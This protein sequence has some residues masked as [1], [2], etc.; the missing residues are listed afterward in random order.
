[1]S[2]PFPGRIIA[3]VLAG[4]FTTAAVSAAEIITEE[5]FI[6]KTIVKEQL[7]KVADNAIF[8][9]D[10]SPSM[11]MN[12]G[13]TDMSAYEVV[14]QEFK[15]R[16][17][18]IPNLGYNFGIYLYT[19]WTPVYP[20]QPYDREKVAEA[21]DSMPAKAS[22]PSFLSEG[23]KET[24]GVL[25]TLNGRTALFAITD[26]NHRPGDLRMKGLYVAE[27]L[28]NNYDVCIYVISTA[29]N[30][31]VNERIMNDIASLNSCSRV[32]PLADFVNRPHYTSGALFDVK[33]TEEVVTVMDKRIVGL[34]ADDLTFEFAEY[35]LLEKDVAELKVVTEFLKTQP[36]AWVSLAGYADNIGSEEVNNRL[37]RQ[38]A[39][40]VANF[41][42]DNGI[43]GQRI[44]VL[45]YGSSNPV[46][47]NDTE[48]GRA[49]NR[50][51]EMAVGL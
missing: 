5:D 4:L 30:E 22:G 50:R 29:R 27:K 26:G 19:R 47:S 41:L 21:L 28:V 23:L 51:V 8:L 32:I 31:E 24:E 43:S 6:Q 2:I 13:D 14:L 37:S 11:N 17:A 7:V 48:E 44:V 49:K 3:G 38:R 40:T 18:N 34:N 46:A 25:K 35:Q 39:E 1:M 33:A 42:V 20:M 9:L 36:E 15:K 45:W 16:N 10:D 12:F